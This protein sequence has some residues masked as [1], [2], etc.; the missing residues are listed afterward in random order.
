MNANQIKNALLKYFRFQRGFPYI[1][2]E[3]LNEDVVA[4]D[5]NNFICVE[6]KISWSDYLREYNKNKYKFIN[7]FSLR[8]TIN[9]PNRIYFAAPK[10]LALK[11]CED[12]NE[13]KSHFGCISISERGDVSII[14]KPKKL[15]ENKIKSE[16]LEL[17]IMR[18]SSELITLRDKLRS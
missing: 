12:L 15:H 2:T 1:A 4:S 10:E 9:N 16:T 13:K 11:I 7:G 18:I 17:I 8:S 5:G 14:R 3:C 6:V